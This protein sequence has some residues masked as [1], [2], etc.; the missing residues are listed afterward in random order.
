MRRRGIG[1]GRAAR[2]TIVWAALVLAAAES[3]FRLYAGVV[4]FFSSMPGHFLVFLSA[5]LLFRGW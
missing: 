4:V 2:Q 1:L 5:H 3:S